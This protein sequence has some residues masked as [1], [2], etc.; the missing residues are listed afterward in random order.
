MN[1]MKGKERVHWTLLNKNGFL[2][3]RRT[4]SPRAAQVLID[5]SD[6]DDGNPYP[7][8]TVYLERL[9]CV[10]AFPRPHVIG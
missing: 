1:G 9:R 10:N 8:D 5:D 6:S 4:V 7:G 2:N 3:R